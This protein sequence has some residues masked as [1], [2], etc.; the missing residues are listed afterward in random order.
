M[1]SP[2]GGGMGGPRLRVC[3]RV[4]A[5]AG[6]EMGAWLLAWARCAGAV[7][8]KPA[9][10]TPGAGQVEVAVLGRSLMFTLWMFG[11]RASRSKGQ[12]HCVIFSVSSCV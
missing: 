6:V 2:T 7:A 11:K 12:G 5:G 10:P 4:G 1:A 9:V 3:R 8:L